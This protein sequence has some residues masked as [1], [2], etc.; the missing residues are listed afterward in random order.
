MASPPKLDAESI[1]A[2]FD[3]EAT[4]DFAYLVPH[5]SSA[6]RAFD[7]LIQTIAKFKDTYPHSIKFIRLDDRSRVRAM[8]EC[9]EGEDE[10]GDNDKDGYAP[11]PPKKFHD[12]LL[13]WRGK[14]ALS[15][16]IKPRHNPRWTAG[17]ERGRK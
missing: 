2:I 13:A 9:S 1:R 8:S 11:T 5:N 12:E 15:L 14:F 17:S 7:E 10:G 4:H 16:R 6:N 3:T